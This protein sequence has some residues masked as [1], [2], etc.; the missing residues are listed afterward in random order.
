[1]VI[2][3]LAVALALLVGGV[4]AALCQSYQQPDTVVVTGPNNQQVPIGNIVVTSQGGIQTPLKNVV[5]NNYL[6]TTT[7]TLNN[8]PM[9][10]GYMSGASFNNGTGADAIFPLSFANLNGPLLE[11]TAVGA[12]AGYAA[13]TAQY[14]TA[15]GWA[16]C[17]SLQTDNDDTCIGTDAGRNIMGAPNSTMVGEG[18]F[19]SGSGNNITALGAY[20]LQGNS[21]SV[22]F[23]GTVANT[24]N[25]CINFTS[26]V[27]TVTNLPASACVAL[28]G[29]DTI[30]TLASKMVTAINALPSMA[31]LAPN[32]TSYAAFAHQLAAFQSGSGGNQIGGLSWSFNGTATNGFS[33]SATESCTVG[34]CAETAA[35]GGGFTGT[36]MTAVGTAALSGPQLS[37]GHDSDAF[38][39]QALAGITTG[40]DNDC[41]GSQCLYSANS[42]YDNVAMGIKAGYGLD[43]PSGA[44]H[45]NI[46][47]G[48]YAGQN[49]TTGSDNVIVAAQPTAS[50]TY[51]C[52]TTGS[53]NVELG[54][55]SC[56]LSPTLNNQLN[57][58]NLIYGRA[59]FGTSASAGEISV[60]ATTFPATFNVGFVSGSSGGGHIAFLTATQPTI[61]SC[62]S[63]PTLGASASDVHGIITPG[64]GA[65]S[66]T[67]TFATT[68]VTN[69]PDCT[70]SGNASGVAPYIG[71]GP[72]LTAFTVNWTTLGKFSYTCLQ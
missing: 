24:D 56:V 43:N 49:I 63:S 10:L 58:G 40:Y 19:K 71:T 55:G 44:A 59:M 64:S 53:F 1:M 28:T 52:I 15:V 27:P 2:K 51:G 3:S 29:A 32:G 65:T 60:G 22:V 18:A 34:P 21:G 9:F 4:S 62:G 35:I 57:I 38:G 54:Y 45:D 36:N 20:T 17:F 69:A 31:G 30:S 33:I 5:V 42:E 11:D 47:V 23:G 61:S 6:G 39:Y 46:F 12:S 50:G 37:T 16:A 48:A 70:V 66:C 68:Y 13:T 8:Y 25:V 72:S 7:S 26:T 67:I 41:M 14:L